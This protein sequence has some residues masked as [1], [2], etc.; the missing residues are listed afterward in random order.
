MS[1]N[2]VTFTVREWVPLRGKMTDAVEK[3]LEKPGEA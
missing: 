2:G 1:G 3:G